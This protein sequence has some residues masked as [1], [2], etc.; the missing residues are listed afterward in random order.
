[1]KG[2][3]EPRS[4]CH[5]GRETAATKLCKVKK[6]THRRQ[7]ADLQGFGSYAERTL[8]FFFFFF[9]L[10]KRWQLTS[11][12]TAWYR[13]NCL[14]PSGPRR[15]GEGRR[16]PGKL[17]VRFYFSYRS[18]SPSFC[19]WFFGFVLFCFRFLVCFFFIFLLGWN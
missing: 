7:E 11:L 10:Y 5:S 6:E 17:C 19:W 14:I 1:M 18:P 4:P 12:Q 3:D 2:Q 15:L 16:D 8:I 13:T 9:P